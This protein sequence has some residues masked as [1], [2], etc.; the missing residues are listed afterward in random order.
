M[1]KTRNSMGYFYVKQIKLKLFGF[2]AVLM[3]IVLYSCSSED[4]SINQSGMSKTEIKSE[5]NKTIGNNIETDVPFSVVENLNIFSEQMFVSSESLEIAL[6]RN[7]YVGFNAQAMQLLNNATNE[8]ELKSAF[9]TGGIAN[10]Q[11]VINSSC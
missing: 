5:K 1:K 10:S 6:N 3:A 11:E 7:S 8:N 9:E 2:L 4:E